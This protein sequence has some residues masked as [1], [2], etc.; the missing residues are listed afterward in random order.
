MLINLVRWVHAGNRRV[1]LCMQPS[2]CCFSHTYLI[3]LL[4]RI[5]CF[6]QGLGR[7]EVN[8][9]M[10][11]VPSSPLRSKAQSALELRSGSLTNACS[12]CKKNC[13]L[14][15]KYDATLLIEHGIGLK[16]VLCR[17]GQ[18]DARWGRGVGREAPAAPTRH[19]RNGEAYHPTTPSPRQP[20]SRTLYPLPSTR[21]SKTR[22]CCEDRTFS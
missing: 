16:G 2:W 8:V 10:Q 6:A 15:R 13:G 5:W 20:S 11:R 1:A 4:D 12:R 7:G 19:L 18:L 14:L 22:V 21:G 9:G 17:G 3:L